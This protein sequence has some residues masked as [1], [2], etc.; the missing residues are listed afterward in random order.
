MSRLIGFNSE[1]GVEKR[2]H[3]HA[4]G[5]WAIE[6]KQDLTAALENNKA[7]QTAEVPKWEGELD[8]RHV[9]FVPFTVMLLWKE[10]YD[11]DYYDPDPAVQKRIDRLLDSS[12]WRHLRTSYTGRLG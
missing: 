12:E 10:L 1:S 9:A 5:T 6:V 11:L 2:W 7:L 8:V 4:D 3:E